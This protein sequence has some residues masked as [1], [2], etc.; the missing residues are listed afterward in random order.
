ML[1]CVFEGW[2]LRDN[3]FP[4][5][6]KQSCWGAKLFS[7]F[8]STHEMEVNFSG[9]YRKK[10]A[11]RTQESNH[12]CTCLCSHSGARGNCGIRRPDID[13]GS[14]DFSGQAERIHKKRH[15]SPWGSIGFPPLLSSP[16][17][18]SEHKIQPLH[19]FACTFS[20]WH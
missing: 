6:N 16:T 12:T 8:Y 10:Q 19:V 7:V 3:I 14:T 17:S 1:K 4:R 5:T 18:A 9:I 15:H 13:L 11:Q 2:H 20:M